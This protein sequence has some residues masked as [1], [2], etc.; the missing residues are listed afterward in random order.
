VIERGAALTVPAREQ[1]CRMHRLHL[2]VP[3][4]SELHHP[5]P[6]YLQ[7][8]IWGE[9]RDLERI[10]LCG[11]GHSDVH[12]AIDALLLGRRIPQGVGRSELEMAREALR[13]FHL[14]GGR[15]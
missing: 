5:F 3:V 7:R 10:P 6:L 13:R 2:P 1:P 8:R 14:A 15:L 9:I 4:A 12:Y 11:T